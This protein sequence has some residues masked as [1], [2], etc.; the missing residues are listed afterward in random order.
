MTAMTPSIRQVPKPIFH[1]VD[2][3]PAP[4]KG[5]VGKGGF[6]GYKIKH[7]LT[8]HNKFQTII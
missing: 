7:R 3:P 6:Q 5:G 1:D 4:L 8:F 2:P